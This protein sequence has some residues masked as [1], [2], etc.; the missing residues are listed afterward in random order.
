MR[1]IRPIGLIADSIDSVI[2]KFPRPESVMFRGHRLFLD[3]NDNLGLDFYNDKELNRFE[4]ETAEKFIQKGDTVIDVGAN[5][6]FFTLIFARAAGREGKI[7]AFEPEPHNLSLLKKNIEAN[8]YKNITIVDKAVGEK[9]E[10]VKLFLSD[11]N[12]GDHRIYDPYEKTARWK[13][14]GVEYDRLSQKGARRQSVETEIVVLDDY[15][16]DYKGPVDFVKIDVQGAEGGV[17]KGMKGIIRKNPQMKVICEF[18]PAGMAMFGVPAEEFLFMLQDLR[19]QFYEIDNKEGL[20][21]L[22]VL[23]EYL[24]E[25]YTIENNLTGNL[26][27]RR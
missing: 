16:S 25:K 26:L 8:N 5:V 21:S 19:F 9:S 3:P 20:G 13:N 1:K 24:L 23:P 4:I 12:V 2:R 22:S 14:S 18:W 6:G 17:V 7:F 11:F 10:K 15:F 27:M